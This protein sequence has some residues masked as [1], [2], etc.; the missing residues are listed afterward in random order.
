MLEVTWMFVDDVLFIAFP[1]VAV[2]L[3]V[4][5]SLYRY[6]TDRFSYSSFSSNSLK[7]RRYSGVPSRGITGF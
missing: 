5:V 6:Y 1:Y 7:V 3:L 4:V 2:V